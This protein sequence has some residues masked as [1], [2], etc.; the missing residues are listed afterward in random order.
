M[1]A[2]DRIR[3]LHMTEAAEAAVRFVAGRQRDELDTDQMLQFAVVR[4]VEVMGEAAN[5][6]SQEI[7]DTYPEIPWKSIVGMR[8]RLV[9]A[10]FDIDTEM[11]WQTL[12]TELPAVL[13]QLREALNSP[14]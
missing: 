8:N 1:R 6:V 3:L 13:R 12:Q 14:T 4:A 7:R 11:V 9:H 10:Y 2:E 5:K